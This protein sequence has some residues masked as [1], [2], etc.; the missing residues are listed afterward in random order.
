MQVRN[1][2][3]R[4]IPTHDFAMNP[5]AMVQRSSF[6]VHQFHKT[7]FSASYLIPIYLEE[8]MPGDMFNIGCQVVCRTAVPVAP[9]IDNWMM[10]FQFFYSPNRIVWDNWEKMLGAQL[11]P[12]DSINYTVPQL[13]SDTSGFLP[14]TIYDYMGLPTVGQVTAGQTVSV[15]ALPLRHYSKIWDDWYRDQNLQT[16]IAPT[17]GNG[18]DLPAWYT[19]KKRGKR[20]DYFTAGLPWL[21]K[22]TAPTIPLGS[23]APVVSTGVA[24]AFDNATFTRT[25]TGI[26]L[27]TGVNTPT[28]SNATAAATSS[29]N[30]GAAGTTVQSLS[31]NLAAA[32][33]PLLNTLRTA[34]ATQQLLER[35]ARGG[36][37]YV[38]TVFA[39]WGVRP[40]DFRLDRPEYIG[41]G[42]IPINTDA[43]PQ[44]S[45]TGLTGGTTPAGTLAATGYGRGKVGFSYAATEHG[46]ILGLV[47]V[48][49]DL[50]YSQGL[51]KHWSRQTRFDFPYPEFANLGEQA[52][53]NKEIYVR[54]SATGGISPGDQDM[55]VFAYMP[56]YD[57]CR[58]FPSQ[59]TGLLRPTTT[60]N[61]AYWHSSQQFS[62]LPTLSSAFIE[63][64][65]NTVLE[66]NFAGGAT[67]ANQQFICDF[68]FT[69]RVARPLP[70]HAIPGLRRF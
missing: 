47:S 13:V 8:V 54:G 56:R 32:S 62:A 9:I 2:K 60:G 14:N 10:D 44:T 64:N 37:R 25:G 70:T 4:S 17:T 69:G 66:R 68:L 1:M 45:A 20:P 18:P 51:R 39:H 43:I 22:F 63:D 35:D 46:Y 59:I 27:T 57:E 36:T 61:I 48:R 5:R 65:T 52:V 41:G 26:N 34:A 3:Q 28:W 19:L 21:Q 31:V 33:G 29:A 38:E 15:S 30:F 11:N 67:S 23:T 55:Q 49:A 12:G 16:S 24:I 42:S 53:Y 6:G 50:T 40:P 7:C 58:H